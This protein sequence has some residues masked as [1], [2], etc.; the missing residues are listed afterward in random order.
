MRISDLSSDVFSS[1][2]KIPL[3]MRTR[4]TGFLAR[5][6]LLLGLLGLAAGV[7]PRAAA[8]AA[9]AVTDARVGVHQ[10]STRFVLDL[11]E[12]L[13]YKIFTLSDPYRVVRPEE[14]R[15]GKEGDRPVRTRWAR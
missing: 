11:S 3:K 2:L 1:D 12:Q 6:V 8:L 14:R 7:F 5:V 10:G 13:P 15:G 9:P 4:M